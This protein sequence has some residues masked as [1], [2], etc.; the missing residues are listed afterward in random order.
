MIRIHSAIKSI[1]IATL[2]S[3]FLANGAQAVDPVRQYQIDVV[4]IANPGVTVEVT[5][6]VSRQIIK[7][8]DS[9]FNDAT[10]GQ[11]R[12]TF[13]K[14]HPIS[15]PTTAT[16]S[17][18]DIQKATG[19][20]PVPDAGF[21]KAILVG[22]I[23]K[24]SA[25]EFAGQAIRGGNYVIMN[26]NWIL[27]SNNGA[28]V[29]FHEL[30]HSLGLGHANS[31]VCTTQLPI[32]CEQREYGDA[33]TR[34]GHFPS[35]WVTNPMIARF[36][37]TELDRLK[38]LQKESKAVAAESG[39]YKLAPVYSKETNLPKVLY[40]PIGNELTY[41]I[42]YRPAIGNDSLLSQ[43]KI[44]GLSSYIDNTP[45]H[46][47]QLRILKTVGTQFK[48]LQP[49]L[50]NYKD[51]ETALV[52]PTLTGDQTQPI[53]KVFTLSDGST[54]TF[55]S[56]DPITGA[57][58]RVQRSPDKDAPLA[59]SAQAFSA[60]AWWVIIL[61]KEKTTWDRTIY[62]KNFDTWDYPVIEIPVNS[63]TDNRLVKLVQIEVNGEVV[64]QIDTPSLNQIEN[65]YYQTTKDG[66]FTLR[67]IATDFAGL[68]TAT[69]PT[70]LSSIYNNII[71]PDLRISSGKDPR[72]SLTLIV[73][74][75]SEKTKYVLDKLSSGK[76]ASIVEKSGRIE[77]AIT[78]ITR[79]QKFTALL[80]G[81]DEMG[82]TDGG[83]EIK[84]EPET[85]GCTNKQCFVGY[86]WNVETGFWRIGA[87]N[88]TLQE[89]IG[90]KWV[91]I[92]TAKPVAG[93]KGAVKEYVTFVMKVNYKTPGKH[94][95][96][97]SIAE[98][99][100]YS[101]RITSAFTQVVLLP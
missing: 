32:V 87:G 70:S 38:V 89:R 16:L 92:Q 80:T 64:G 66:R 2:I 6:E 22:V 20:T 73:E 13:R 1:F 27:T 67:L 72:T 12:F 75:S 5:E 59:L 96:R 52:V 69:Q 15:S 47:L 90:S 37:A 63:V 77:Y 86:Q 94:T 54:L 33:S 24:T 39:D 88:M 79:N 49:T 76:I 91:D 23:A 36:S 19:L 68:S 17:S 93:P 82:Y 60:Q 74:P 53:G 101:G 98:S 46:G 65:Y 50:T 58:V 7:Q 55:L 10:G 11:I 29:L 41:S 14:L 83:S 100:K 42:E 57:T 18:S 97:L 9:A 61:G 3:V 62:K 40:I 78:N 48:E 4:P 81:T 45:S 56:A 28:S 25:A 85:T 99:K 31:T 34:M 84:Y 26:G 44:S 35:A 95:Y 30:G 8:V 51:L 71:S 21:E 43:S